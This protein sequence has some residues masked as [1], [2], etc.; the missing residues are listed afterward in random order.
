V[1]K[2]WSQLCPDRH[3]PQLHSPDRSA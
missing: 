3:K 2:L 1:E